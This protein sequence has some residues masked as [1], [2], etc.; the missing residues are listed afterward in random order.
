MHMFVFS[1]LPCIP[2]SKKV[3]FEEVRQNFGERRVCGNLPRKNGKRK[4]VVL[5]WTIRNS[6]EGPHS[7]MHAP[8]GPSRLLYN[9]NPC[10][11]KEKNLLSSKRGTHLEPQHH[12][13]TL[14]WKECPCPLGDLQ[15]SKHELLT[16]FPSTEFTRLCTH[17]KTASRPRSQKNIGLARS[18]HLVVRV[19]RSG[20]QGH[21]KRASLDP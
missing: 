18:R 17:F 19:C 21:N 20:G 7:T 13:P 9:M 5:L 1:D 10:V 6:M 14:L 4:P 8:D 2:G 15:T 16:N 11:D 12:S 3:N